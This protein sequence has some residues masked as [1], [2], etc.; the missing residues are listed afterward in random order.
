[1][2][3]LTVQELASLPVFPFADVFPLLAEEELMELSQ[4]IETHGLRHPVVLFNDQILDGRNRIRALKKVRNLINIPVEVFEGSEYEAVEMIRSLNILRRHLSV[5]QRAMA[6]QE[7][8]P[9]EESEAKRRM[10]LGGQG[11]LDQGVTDPS[12]VGSDGMR[13]EPQGKARDIVAE[14]FNLSG[15]RITE[16]KK[17]LMN[18]PD[19]AEKVKSGEMALDKAYRETQVRQTEHEK[20]RKE[21]QEEAPDLYTDYV[22]SSKTLDQSYMD[23]QTRKREA[24]RT[25]RASISEAMRLIN[26]IHDRLDESIREFNLTV[27]KLSIQ[28]LDESMDFIDSMEGMLQITYESLEKAKI[29]RE[30]GEWEN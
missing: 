1:M 27:P 21:L 7:Y 9:Y 30:S 29:M 8:L 2:T 20:K 19:L 3:T 17:V 25:K 12:P 23:L 16:A 28:Q 15:P 13:T 18:A 6:A 24:A 11:G 5:G 14:K 4:D 10:S 22:G 26:T